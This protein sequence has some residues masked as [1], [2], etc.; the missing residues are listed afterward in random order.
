MVAIDIAH[1]R[2]IIDGEQV[3]SVSGETMPVVN[4]AT[5]VVGGTVPR[6][7]REDVDRAVAAARSLPRSLYVR[8]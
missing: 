6:A 2:M 4:P 3:D 1:Y 8:S 5:N 7:T